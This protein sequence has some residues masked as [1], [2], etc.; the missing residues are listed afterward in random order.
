MKRSSLIIARILFVVYLAAIAYLCLWNFQHLP[1]VSRSFF[2]IPTDK[3]VHF[4]MF[5][6]YPILLYFAIGKKIGKPKMAI[7][8]ILLIFISGCIIAAGTEYLQGKTSYRTA[9]I[10]DFKADSISLAI[11][12]LIVFIT[13]LFKKE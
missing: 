13:D 5:L 6:P 11:G 2:G 3:I 9:D 4:L 7:L 8:F 10:K 12:S 1:H